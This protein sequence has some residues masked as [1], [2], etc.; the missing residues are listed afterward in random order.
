MPLPFK[1]FKKKRARRARNYACRA[2]ISGFFCLSAAPNR[3]LC[4]LKDKQILTLDGVLTVRDA[5][6]MAVRLGHGL[7]EGAAIGTET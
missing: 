5:H 2:K 7:E 6:D 4:A 3:A 1:T